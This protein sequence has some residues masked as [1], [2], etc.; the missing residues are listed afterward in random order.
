MLGMRILLV[1]DHALT[2]QSIQCYFQ[3]KH[4]VTHVSTCND[5]ELQLK[6]HRYDAIILDLTLPDGS[7]ENLCSTA[8]DQ[9]NTPAVLIVSGKHDTA[10]KVRTLEA[11]ADDYITKPFTSAEL[12]ARVVA[13]TR[14]AK[15]VH[16]LQPLTFHGL[17][18]QENSLHFEKNSVTLTKTEHQLI[19]HFLKFPQ[20]TVPKENLCAVI[21]R[22]GERT[23]TKNSLEVHLKNL[24]QKLQKI[25][26]T[27]QLKTIYGLG[28]RLEIHAI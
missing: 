21:N 6:T 3:A 12:Y 20:Q 19:S 14:R 22:K 4:H 15:R 25:S 24:R 18:I 16:E 11:G 7:G 5:A 17:K 10:T 26:K 13:T 23:K 27:H 1:E 9:K 28:Y 8:A 2:A